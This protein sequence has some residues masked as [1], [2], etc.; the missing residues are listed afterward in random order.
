M[1]KQPTNLLLSNKPFFSSMKKDCDIEH[2]Y[3]FLKMILVGVFILVILF[4]GFKLFNNKDIFLI[5]KNNT[6]VSEIE[7]IKWDCSVWQ[8]EFEKIQKPDI[9]NCTEEI[10]F[11]NGV[12]IP[13]CYIRNNLESY[14]F[15]SQ[16]NKILSEFYEC[17][18]LA[19][20]QNYVISKEDLSIEW[21][22]NNCETARC[23]A[24]ENLECKNQKC[25]LYYCGDY[26]VEI[27]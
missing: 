18:Y 25:D 6:E 15:Q 3:L 23:T 1:E 19:F 10:N 11:D 13:D 12:K 22:E 9:Q 21:L 14:K 7:Y 5:T 26:E 2:P 20:K 4:I 27:N 8:E 17:Q 16:V 24:C